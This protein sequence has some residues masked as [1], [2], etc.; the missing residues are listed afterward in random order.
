[1]VPYHNHGKRLLRRVLLLLG[2]ASIL[3]FGL[4][5]VHSRSQITEGGVLGMTLL[6]QHWLLSRALAL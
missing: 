1:M 2:G 6:L 5:N 3:A 4:F